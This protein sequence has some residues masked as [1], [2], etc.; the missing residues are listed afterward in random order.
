MVLRELSSS[1]HV[2]NGRACSNFPS[3]RQLW[4]W[5]RR[6]MPVNLAKCHRIQEKQAQREQAPVHVPNAGRSRP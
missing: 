2:G 1:V 3:G 5:G 4:R 6:F